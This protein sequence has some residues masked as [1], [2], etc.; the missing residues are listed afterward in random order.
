MNKVVIALATGFTL[1]ILFAPRKGSETRQRLVDGFD[2]LAANID[3]IRESFSSTFR[4]AR[5]EDPIT[6][7]NDTI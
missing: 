3:D 1:G 4:A 6:T 5:E 7:M 2:D